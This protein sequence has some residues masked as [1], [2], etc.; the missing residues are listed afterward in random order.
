MPLRHAATTAALAWALTAATAAGHGQSTAETFT[1]TAAVKSVA[2]GA[3]ASAPVTV[4]V[5]RRMSSSDAERFATAFKNG[6]P[7]GL[8]KALVGEPPTG[9][10]TV[11]SAAAMPTRI[12][13]ERRTDKGRLLTIVTDTPLMFLG[14]GIPGAKPTAGY[15]FGV[16]D[17]EVDDKGAGTGVIALAAKIGLNK[18]AF[19]V[20]EYSQELIR[21]TNVVKVK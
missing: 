14:A 11:G 20:S 6:G 15:D 13:L 4:V 5:Q 21:L 19:V 2:G 9:S 1:A 10:V 12:T 7:A 16:I 17:L 3:T 8:R 18:D